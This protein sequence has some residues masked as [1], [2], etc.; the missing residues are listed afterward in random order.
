[1][2]LIPIILA[3]MQALTACSS[4]TTPTPASETNDTKAASVNASGQRIAL[5]ELSPDDLRVTIKDGGPVV[6]FHCEARDD[7]GNMIATRVDV[8]PPK[9]LFKVE[10]EFARLAEKP[11]DLIEAADLNNDGW[12]DV[13]TPWSFGMHNGYYYGWVWDD[14]AGTFAKVP[15]FEFLSDPDPLPGEKGIRSYA[16]VSAAEHVYSLWELKGTTL[17]RVREVGIRPCEIEDGE[18]RPKCFEQVDVVYENGKPRETVKKITAAE[19]MEFNPE[20]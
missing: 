12:T 6:D 11:C 18:E 2:K 16:H 8:V 15:D 5:P 17:S 1:M 9:Q 19:A 4:K 10:A 14:K 13:M 20:F 7:L 3:L